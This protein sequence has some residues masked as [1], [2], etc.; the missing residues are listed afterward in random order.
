MTDGEGSLRER[1]RHLLASRRSHVSDYNC[2]LPEDPVQKNS[3]TTPSVKCM[4]QTTSEESSIHTELMQ[5][6]GSPDTTA[7]VDHGTNIRGETEVPTTGLRVTKKCRV[8]V[9]Q[10]VSRR[11]CRLLADVWERRWPNVLER[12]KSHPSEA[13]C[14]S[15]LSRRTALHLASF[16]HGCP[17]N[18]AEALIQANPHAL[19]REDHY[20]HT[21]LH[22]VSFF[23][24]QVRTDNLV[25]LFCEK[26]VEYHSLGMNT[27]LDKRA[28]SVK[29]AASP[30]Y[31]EIGRAHV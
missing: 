20:G 16:S 12:C 23:S 28:A 21:P 27:L 7:D 14:V 26:L 19:S 17:T 15:D 9:Y 8:P 3:K 24:F 1:H 10:E 18:V 31:V 4:Q 25:T 2:H 29:R 22:L 13:C 5:P 6:Q 11:Q 30:L